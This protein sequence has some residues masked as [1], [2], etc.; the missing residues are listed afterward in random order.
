[1]GKSVR[2]IV[3]AAVLIAILPVFFLGMDKWTVD[4]IKSFLSEHATLNAFLIVIA[5]ICNFL[6]HGATQISAA[7]I[8]FMAGKY[9]YRPLIIP[10]KT[11]LVTL[12]AS[13]ISVQII[14]HL[15][16]R[17]R[18]RITDTFIAIG[19]TLN[20]DYDSFPSGHTALAFSIAFVLS[21]YFKRYSA[22]FYS[23]AML[24]GFYRVKEG[25]HFPSD[26]IAG[27]FAGMVVTKLL[28]PK[29][30]PEKEHPSTGSG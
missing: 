14:K 6:F 30:R 2:Q 28:M 23:I 21:S 10:G 5:P 22:V 1:M 8:L 4:L 11:F 29:L 19:P 3:P 16:G 13:G 17:A 26:V 24:S 12:L 15:V 27:A 20:M 18:P 7:F 25:S 9:L